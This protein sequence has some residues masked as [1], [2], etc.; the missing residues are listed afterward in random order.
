MHQLAW[1]RRYDSE[2]ESARTQLSSDAFDKA[3]NEGR[4][5][6]LDQA[7]RYASDG[8]IASPGSTA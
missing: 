2:V 5:M 3:R 8:S 4:A 1:Q 7:V 6:T